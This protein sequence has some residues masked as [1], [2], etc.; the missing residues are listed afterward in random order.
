MW[1]RHCKRC[2]KRGYEGKGVCR[3][4]SPE[5]SRLRSPAPPVH[6]PPR[7][8]VEQRLQSQIAALEQRL[9]SHRAQSQIG[10]PSPAENEQGNKT[11]STADPEI[12]SEG[13]FQEKENEGC[14][15]DEAEWE[16]QE[17][18]A[19]VWAE[20]T[21]L[22]QQYP[23]EYLEEGEA[24]PDKAL[25]QEGDNQALDEEGDEFGDGCPGALRWK[26]HKAN[27]GI[28]R[29]LR[30][31]A[32]FANLLPVVDAWDWQRR[33]GGA[34]YGT[35]MDFVGDA[36]ELMPGD[37]RERI[38]RKICAERREAKASQPNDQEAP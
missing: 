8:V 4:C 38:W 37:L 25:D 31:W 36:R 10:G 29:D 20:D 14:E 23:A 6:P 1:L 33:T 27:K 32:R 26:P 18:E 11:T 35:L 28:L 13:D 9:Q 30:H 16:V 21:E 34:S 22:D 24:S 5:G 2:G 15:E 12:R 7:Q 3:W 19:E 17:K